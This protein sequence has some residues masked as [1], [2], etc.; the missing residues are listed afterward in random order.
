[1]TG[2][3]KERG[4]LNR[5]QQLS[6][7]QKAKG[8]I[9]A[10]AGNHAQGLAYHAQRL[11]I[12]ATIAMPEA[13]PQNKVQSVRRFGPDVVLHGKNFDESFEEAAALQQRHG[14]TFVHPF[15]DEA[16]IAGQ[17]TIAVEMLE[18][19]PLLD[20]IVV[21][22]G[23]GGL[24]AGVAT[25]AKALK[26]EIKIIGVQSRQASA[27]YSAVGS[28][29]VM[30]VRPGPTIADGIAVKSPGHLTYPIIR[31][32]VDQIVLVDEEEIAAAVLLLLER[33]K[34]LAEGAGACPLAA[35]M[36][37]EE[38]QLQG[39]HVAMIISGG[40]IDMT[41]LSRIIERG[42]VKDGRMARL[43]IELFD[44]PGQLAQTSKI[45]AEQSA[46]VL[47][48]YHNRSFLPASMGKTYLDV[49]LE[50]RGPEHVEAI[51]AALEEQG[52]KTH[53]LSKN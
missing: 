48:V 27:M 42:M 33:E 39:K 28:G 45:L 25:A 17:G 1:M 26:P 9:T 40:N 18:D 4:A 24:I 5:L 22:I 37:R 2:A 21:P 15:D 11:G 3:F 29:H 52:Y 43:R 13:T 23:G 51:I 19:V 36:Y 20:A 46:N 35:M 38:L 30:P 47:E 10:S 32:L 31:D 53:I 7:E 12:K 41:L 44:I 14:F 34:T 49:T 16:V 6:D 8:V 50:T